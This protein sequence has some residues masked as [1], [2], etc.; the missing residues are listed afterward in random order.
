LL[1]DQP[2]TYCPKRP[3]GVTSIS[4]ARAETVAFRATGQ[5]PTCLETGK[6][7]RV[8]KGIQGDRVEVLGKFDVYAQTE[9]I[10]MQMHPRLFGKNQKANKPLHFVYE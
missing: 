1:R 2:K 7:I 10:W 5:H 3:G 8:F 4:E 6:Q 9:L